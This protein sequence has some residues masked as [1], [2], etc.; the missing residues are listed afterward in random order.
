MKV[1][2]F[3]GA[4]TVS[5]GDGFSKAMSELELGNRVLVSP[6]E[7]CWVI[8]WG[9]KQASVASSDYVR[10][11]WKFDKHLTLS[12]GRFTSSNRKLVPSHALR[13]GVMMQETEFNTSVPIV[14]VQYFAN[15]KGLCKSHVA[16]GAIMVNCVLVST[17][18]VLPRAAHARL[19]VKRLQ[20]ALGLSAQGGSLD[21]QTPSFSPQNIVMTSK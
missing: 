13:V 11:E 9:H 7:I 4:G 12:K 15:A 19:L 6:T 2:A 21:D 8:V 18:S 3:L 1:T 16:H 10:V 5:L 17:H 14:F 20:S